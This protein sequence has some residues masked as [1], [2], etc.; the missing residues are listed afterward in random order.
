MTER[1]KLLEAATPIVKCTGCDD[2]WCSCVEHEFKMGGIQCMSPA[3][4]LEEG[5]DVLSK[6]DMVY[7]TNLS[8]FNF[9]LD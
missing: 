7:L 5:K 1:M 3:E 8:R 6:T 4:M 2:C 9:V